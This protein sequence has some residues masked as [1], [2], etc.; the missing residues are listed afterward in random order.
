L[1]IEWTDTARDHLLQLDQYLSERSPSGADRVVDR[2]YEVVQSLDR[3]PLTGRQGRVSGTRELVIPATK[4]I[5]AY[6]IVDEVIHILAILH[7]AQR[8]PGHFKKEK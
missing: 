2:I 5:V 7:G 1:R 3:F 8:W 6:R 4:Y